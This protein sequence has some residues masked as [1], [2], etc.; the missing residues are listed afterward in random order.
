MAAQLTNANVFDQF[1]NAGLPPGFALDQPQGQ[2]AKTFEFTSPDGKKFTVNGPPGS[3]PEQAFSILQQHQGQSVAGPD[4]SQMS[5][6]DLMAHF[7]GQ[8]ALP[9]GFVLDQHGAANGSGVD[10]GDIAKSAGIGLAKGAVGLAGLP[11]DLAN[12]ASRGYDYVSG[13]HTNATVAPY[14]NAI[15]ADNIQKHIEGLTGPFYEPKTTGGQYAQTI[16]EFAPALF[17]GPE[18]LGA[19]LMTRVVAPGVASEAAGQATEGTALEPVARIAGALTSAAGASKAANMLTTRGLARAAPTPTVDE[20]QHAAETAYNSPEVTGLRLS[21]QGVQ[22]ITSDARDALLNGKIDEGNAPRVM[23]I[24]NNLERGPR[25]ERP[26]AAN[27]NP[28]YQVADLDLARQSLSD[29]PFEERRAASVVRGVIDRYLGNIPHS[30]VIAGDAD[31]ANRTLLEARGNYAGMKRSEAV[32]DAMTRAE[33]QAGSTYSGANLENATR[34]QLRPI[35]NE[36]MGVAKRRGF[37]DYTDEEV[38]ALRNAVNGTAVGNFIRTAGGYLGKGG[39]LGA[40]AS[41][42]AIGGSAAE[43]GADPLTAIG[44]G[45]VGMAGGRM[46]GKYANRLETNRANAVG[47]MLRTR[48]PL[49]QSRGVPVGGFKTPSVLSGAS[50][51]ELALQALLTRMQQKPLSYYGQQNQ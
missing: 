3:T 30:D 28:A 15:G 19:K 46:L 37:Q 33:N 2:S 10:L 42:G 17:G 35:L 8:R 43:A 38:G 9:S 5:D 14:A 36:K 21:Q 34:Q 27:P 47:D 4:Y 22:Q 40:V 23:G 12:L 16:G 45:L 51:Q 25:F 20:L 18:S 49:A 31:A 41:G 11:G 32:T 6:A 44:L 26:T 29:V 13:S 24:V 50:P 39:G 7:G 48:T 1:D